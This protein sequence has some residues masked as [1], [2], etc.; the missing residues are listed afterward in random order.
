MAIYRLNTTKYVIKVPKKH[1]KVLKFNKTNIARIAKR[2]PEIISSVVEVSICLR[3]KD[4]TITTTVT[5][6]PITT[7]TT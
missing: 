2:C 4:A 6:V 7:I 5:T 1:K 3:K